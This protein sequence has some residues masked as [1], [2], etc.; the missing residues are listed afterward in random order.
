MI[1]ASIIIS[2]KN[3]PHDLIKCLDSLINQTY[4][5]LELIIIDAGDKELY[6]IINNFKELIDIKYIRC[7]TSL[8][9]AR[10]I[11]IQRSNG[12]VII[13]LDDDVVL[14]NRFIYFIINV[15][16]IY[17]NNVGAVCGNIVNDE[18]AGRG[19]SIFINNPILRRIRNSIFRLFFLYCW[20]DGK[21]QPSG[22]PT[23]PSRNKG[24]SF[25]E[26][27]PGANMA[28]RK[29]VLDKIKFDEK[30]HG[31]CF[32]ED[33]DISYRVLKQYKIIYSPFAELYHNFSPASRDSDRLRMKMLI[34]S[35]YYLFNKNFPHTF[36]N[37]LAFRVSS[38]GLFFI[39]LI[40][41]NF[42]EMKG[43]FIGLKTIFLEKFKRHEFA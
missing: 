8:T 42:E 1:T 4:P 3:R 26:C 28:F 33:C 14:D 2:T 30:L 7:K 25:I 23:Y 27:L 39:S 24:I 15:F 41:L 29:E 35:H 32:M 40:Q 18:I 16:E 36:Y 43:L 13:F 34:E 21:F 37:N 31:Y 22:M 12:N 11:G 19:F 10:N 38:F 20:N 9:A 6:D 5:I 17:G